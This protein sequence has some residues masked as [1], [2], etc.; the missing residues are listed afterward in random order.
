MTSARIGLFLTLLLGVPSLLFSQGAAPEKKPQA[1][2]MQEDIEIMRRILNRAVD[3]PR[4][5]QQAVPTSNANNVFTTWG[6]NPTVLNPNQDPVHHWDTWNN[7]GI[8]QPQ[9]IWPNTGVA[10]VSTLRYPAAEGVYLKGHGVVLTLT[11]PPQK[12][13]MP[14]ATAPAEKSLTEWERVRKE[15]RGEK[16]D[17]SGAD[18][19]AKEPTIADILIKVLAENGKHFTQ[20]APDETVTIVVTFRQT[21]GGAPF[22]DPIYFQL[23]HPQDTLLRPNQLNLYQFPTAQ[24][25]NSDSTQVKKAGGDTPASGG[26]VAT[27]AAS[28]KVKDSLLLG[29]LH[30]KQ[31]KIAEAMEAYMVAFNYLQ[32]SKESDAYAET[33]R[34]LAQCLLAENKTEEAKQYL[35]LVIKRKKSAEPAPAKQEAPTTHSPTKL[36]VSAQKK[37]LDQVGSGKM[38]LEEFKKEVIVEYSGPTNSDKKE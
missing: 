34:K 30:Y 15:L 8:N 4:Y 13:L 21:E 19:K 32:E 17:G 20:L 14:T 31:G 10:T 22:A 16:T 12:D 24:P 28:G 35:D 1:A 7:T 37:L 38:T 18:K 36:I 33:C 2:Q 29:D 6:Q 5:A 26:E 9:L 23:G 11:L 25:V 27:K 3:L